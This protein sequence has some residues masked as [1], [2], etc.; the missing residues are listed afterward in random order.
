MSLAWC[1]ALLSV[2]Q[3]DVD[4]QQCDISICMNNMHTPNRQ[5]N[6]PAVETAAKTNNIIES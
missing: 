2:S 5:N 6:N 1:Y 4:R 3:T